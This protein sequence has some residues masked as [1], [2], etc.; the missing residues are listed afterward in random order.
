MRSERTGL[1]RSAPEKR[2]KYFHTG[3]ADIVKALSTLP[4]TQ[5]PLDK[6][7][8]FVVDLF[9]VPNLVDGAADGLMVNIQGELTESALKVEDH[10]R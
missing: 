2:V 10:R 6:A 5:H 8:N 7:D 3:Q 4:P 1:T 9:A